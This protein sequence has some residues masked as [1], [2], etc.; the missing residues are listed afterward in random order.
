MPEFKEIQFAGQ[1]LHLDASGCLYWPKEKA[2]IVSDLHLEKGSSFLKMGRFA[3]PYDSCETLERLK[4]II[5]SYNVEILILLGDTLHDPNGFERLNEDCRQIFDE[6]CET[7]KVIWII[8][9]HEKGFVPPKVVPFIEYKKETLIFR[10]EA[11]HDSDAGEISGHFHP[12]ATLN[13]KGKKIRQR[14]FIEDGKRMMLPAFGSYTGS[15]D[16]SDKAIR[17]FFNEPLK[18]YMLSKTKVYEV[19]SD[20]C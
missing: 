15:L 19:N 13:H 20:N 6:L 1:H 8:G 12:C 10:H 18:I 11:E 4:K 9:N 3:P 17:D 5:K 7:Y 14:C 16:V 2:L